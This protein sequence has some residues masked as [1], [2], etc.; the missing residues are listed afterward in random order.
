MSLKING[1]FINQLYWILR[2]FVKSSPKDFTKFY[3]SNLIIKYD[4]YSYSKV[5]LVY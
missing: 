4:N 3:K 5:L 1:M 2:N